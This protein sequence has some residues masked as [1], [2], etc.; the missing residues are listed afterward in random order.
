[1]RLLLCGALLG[2]H[3]LLLGLLCAQAGCIGLLGAGLQADAIRFAAGLLDIGI[4]L[5]RAGRVGGDLG[6]LAAMYARWLVS[7]VSLSSAHT[8]SAWAS[9]SVACLSSSWAYWL[10][11]GSPAAVLTAVRASSRAGDGVVLA[12]AASRPTAIRLVHRAVVR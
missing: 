10:T 9:A 8:R 2:A 5:A 4:E 3:R 11:A 12:Q 6:T 7:D 1:L